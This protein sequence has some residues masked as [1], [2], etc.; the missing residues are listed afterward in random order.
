MY[1][2]I[3]FIAFWRQEMRDRTALWMTVSG[4]VG[5]SL[6]LIANFTNIFY[7]LNEVAGGLQLL[8]NLFVFVSWRKGYLVSS[9]FKNLSR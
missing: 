7:G 2:Y 9:G 3:V 6:F 4:A 8:A 1:K 5:F